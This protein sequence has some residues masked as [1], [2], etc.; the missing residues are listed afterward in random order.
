MGNCFKCYQK[1]GRISINFTAKDLGETGILAPQGMSGEDKVC[2]K[3]MITLQNS[4]KIDDT[5]SKK[6]MESELA[7]LMIKGREYK[8]KWNKDGIIQFKNERIAILKR[9]WGKQVEFIVAYDDLTNQGYRLMAH[10]E[11]K[12]GS[13]GGISGGINSY[14]YFQKIEFV[15][16]GHRELERIEPKKID[17]VGSAF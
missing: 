17:N 1:F 5:E 6:E 11:G 10:D 16:V 13:A 9:M 8:T 4:Q 2:S 12:E 3:C 14:F 15:S 7:N